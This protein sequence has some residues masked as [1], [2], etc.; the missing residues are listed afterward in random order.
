MPASEGKRDK[1]MNNVS[2]IYARDRLI[3]C[4]ETANKEINEALDQKVPEKEL[5]ARVKLFVG[6]AFKKCNVDFNNPSK[7]G[8]LKAMDLC[9]RNTEKILGKKGAKIVEKHYNEM[10]EIMSRIQE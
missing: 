2:T 5:K 1:A 8:L 3:N 6:D 7:D 4:F 9:K 10:L